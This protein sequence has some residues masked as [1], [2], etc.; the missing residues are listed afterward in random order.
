MEL[1]IEK[2]IYGGDAL[3]RIQ[4]QATG[5]ARAVFVPFAIPGETVN[6]TFTE[7]KPGFTRARLDSVVTP[8]TAR[9]DPPCPYFYRCGGCHY[10]HIRYED[11]LSAKS[12]I[13]EET[14]ARTAKLKLDKPVAAHASPPWNYRN[15]T[16]MRVAHEPQFAIG[17]YRFGSHT[18]LP[19]EQCPI[20]SPLINRALDAL[21]QAGRDGRIDRAVREVQFFSNHDDGRILLELYA[22]QE[23]SRAR[24]E[25]L[26]AAVRN[27]LPELAG[28]A[29]FLGAPADDGEDQRAPLTRSKASFG[30]VAGEDFLT[31]RVSGDDFH[32]AAGSFFQTNRFLLE[33][34]TSLVTR[35]RSGR[36]ALDLY[37]GAGLFSIPLARA[38]DKVVAV[39]ISPHSFNDLTANSPKNVKAV[40]RSTEQFLQTEGRGIG[41]DYIVVD[42]PRGGLGME[43]ARLL[44]RTSARRITYVSCDPATLSRDVRVLIES[45]F[46]VEEAHVVD[47]FPQTFHLESILQLVR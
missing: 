28:I 8:A 12:S 5:R 18:L 20:S 36:L 42:P 7:Q 37:A 19:V 10:Q 35:E 30:A 40:R 4:D 17:Y 45:G 29:V 23:T 25:D 16:R 38:F 31:Y 47:L 33:E 44:G 6:A 13:L 43:T 24:V 11:Q 21:W 2:L 14:L 3:A 41:A 26:A 9:V 15:R 46:H 27:Q 39:E 34:M 1:K 32:V 22:S